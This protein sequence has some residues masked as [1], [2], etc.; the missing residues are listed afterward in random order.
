MKIGDH[1]DVVLKYDI[2]VSHWATDSTNRYFRQTKPEFEDHFR[3]W[4]R[5][6]LQSGW[7]LYF[8]FQEK[9]VVTVTD[10]IDYDL[11]ILTWGK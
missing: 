8:Y 2:P 5:E 11:L 10:E 9:W 6:N 1:F 4:A 7:S 3:M